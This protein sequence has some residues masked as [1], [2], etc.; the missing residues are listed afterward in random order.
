M[1]HLMVFKKLTIKQIDVKK[2]T[3]AIYIAS[4]Q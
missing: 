3:N 2:Y 4:D 1:I